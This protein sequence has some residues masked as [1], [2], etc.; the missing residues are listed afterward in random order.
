MGLSQLQQPEKFKGVKGMEGHCMAFR[1]YILGN[2]DDFTLK[3]IPF[4]IH[5]VHNSP[6]QK[7]DVH[8]KRE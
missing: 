3:N 1:S 6:F 5:K 2:L 7:L 4:V 8:D